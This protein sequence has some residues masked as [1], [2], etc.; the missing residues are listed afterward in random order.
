MTT[1]GEIAKALGSKAVRA[2]GTAIA[3]NPNAPI[4]PC[5]RVVLSSGKLGNYSAGDGVITKIKL[6]ES[7]GVMVKDGYIVDFQNHLY[8]F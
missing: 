1:Y 5:H 6:L 7:E 8:H 3:K 2:V 4:V